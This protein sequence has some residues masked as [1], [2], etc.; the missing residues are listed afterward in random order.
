MISY[1]PKSVEEKWKKEWFSKSIYKAENSSKKPKKYVLVEFPYPSGEGLHVG[2]A[3]TMT[4]A[5]VYARKK[6]MEGYNVLFPMGWDAFGLPTENYAI[7]TGIKPQVATAKNT[8]MFKEQMQS[9]GFSFDWSREVN[10][11]DPNY[12]KWTQWI[13]TELFKHG[14]AYK[15]KMAINWCPKCKIGLANEEVVRRKDAGETG[16]G[17]NKQ[18]EYDVNVCERCGTPVE[19]KELDQW[20]LKITAY[21]DRLADDLDL[22]DFP[23]SV[24]ASQRN[25]IGRSEGAQIKF[26]IKHTGLT[27]SGGNKQEYIEVFTTRPD[28]IFGAT[29][30][31]ISPEHELVDVALSA[32]E[33]GFPPLASLARRSGR[34]AFGETGSPPDGSL[35]APSTEIINYVKQ[36]RA[37]SELE[38]TELSKEKTGVFSGLYAINPA[39]GK[40]IPIWISDFV[41]ST[42][43][44]GAIMAVPANDDRDFEFAKRY[45]LPITSVISEKPENQKSEIRNLPYVGYGILTNSGNFTGMK[46]EEAIPAICDWLKE[47][48]I[49]E[50]ATTYH[51][52]DWIF[53]RQH[54]WGEPIPMVS[55]EKC[56]WVPV[57]LSE[58]PVKLPEIEKYQP[59]GTGESPLA[60]VKSFVETKCPNCGGPARR[61]TDTMPNWAGSS[62]Y[63]LAY[64]FADA[65]KNANKNVE[66]TFPP[67]ASIRRSGRLAFGETDRSPSSKTNTGGL[68]TAATEE[69]QKNILSTS[70]DILSYWLPVDTYFGGSEHT[71]LHLL[72]S[73]FWHKFLY[74]M[75]LVPNPEPY[76]KRIV[77]GVILGPDGARMSKS[78]G[79]VINPDEVIDA[80]SADILRLYFLFMGPF[81]GTMAWSNDG[82]EGCARFLNRVWK[83]ANNN[84]NVSVETGYISSLHTRHKLHQTIKKVGSDIDSFHFNT[85]IAAMMEFINVWSDSKEALSK[86]DL[87]SFIKILAPFAPF[88]AEEIYSVL[89][90]PSLPGNSNSR[91]RGTDLREG[92]T[93]H[94]SE[95]PK[96]DPELV[97]EDEVTI[98]VQINGKLRSTFK[99]SAEKATDDVFVTSSAKELPEIASRLLDTAIIKTIFVTGKLVNI[100]VK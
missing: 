77:H 54:Y 15:K 79:N 28:T 96:F 94:L 55:C 46:S 3:F 56:G 13:F 45:D 36:A 49:G 84:N 57:P 65:L 47:E 48:G 21:A 2:H 78:K 1:D 42:Y 17:G 4:G 8:K 52:R 97:K 25:W 73:R 99:I 6:R 64:C 66:E 32:V 81:E 29:F 19:K 82:V 61:E 18:E 69:E 98:A 60:S 70:S 11:S 76:Q 86:E 90:G 26:K 20:L 100:V 16:N 51:L 44:T 43:G 63:Y 10:T 23:E 31:V 68:K 35:K 50:A 83:L 53:S 59:T 71:T 89:R 80:Y 41:L 85:A 33:E 91:F 88:M 74:D 62:W 67:L 34:L 58:L 24:K 95:W 27:G 22:V 38:R 87:I 14:L 30:L 92:D 72:Y 93:I 7:K 75:K 40:E 37:K 39:T 12:Y 5:D 9:L